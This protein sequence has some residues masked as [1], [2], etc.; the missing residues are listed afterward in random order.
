VSSEKTDMNGPKRAVRAKLEELPLQC[1]WTRQPTNDH[2]CRARVPARR[3]AGAWRRELELGGVRAGFFHFEWR[4]E[5]WLAYGLPDGE[6]RGVYCPMHRT[7]RE[8]RL[9]Y[10]PELVRTATAAAPVLAGRAG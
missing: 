10:D 8:Q 6:V 2:R 4:G 3:V 9:G 7:Q 5:Q 1:V